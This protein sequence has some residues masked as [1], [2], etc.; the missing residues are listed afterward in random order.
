[1]NGAA[2]IAALVGALAS[3][4]AAPV[5]M[6]FFTGPAARRF[7]LVETDNLAHVQMWPP[8]SS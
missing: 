5:S 1:V 2:Q 8:P 4:T 6:F 7:L 3:L